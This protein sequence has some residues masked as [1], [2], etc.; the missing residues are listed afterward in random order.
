MN[1]PNMLTIFRFL[2]IPVFIAFFFSDMESNLFYSFIVFFVAGITDVLDGFIARRFNMITDLGKLLDPLADKFMLISVLIC[3][4]TTDLISIWILVIIIIKEII[5]VLGAMHLY[6][7]KVQIIIPSNKYGK[8]GTMLFYL[9]ICSVLL[10]FNVLF[11]KITLY[12]A[13]AIAILAFMSYYHIAKNE[14]SKHK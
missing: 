7:S 12:S 9:A 2:L 10:Q 3:L 4:A 6:Y 11:S 5:M 1:I 8:I 13:V 14:K